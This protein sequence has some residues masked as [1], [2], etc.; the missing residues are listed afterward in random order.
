MISA[1]ML[2]AVYV[3][4]IP[5]ASKHLCPAKLQTK[6]NVCCVCQSICLFFPTDSGVPRAVDVQKC[7]QPNIV[8]GCVLVRAAHSRLYPLQKVHWVFGN[9][10]MFN[11]CVTLCIACVAACIST[12][13][14][15]V[16]TPDTAVVLDTLSSLLDRDRPVRTVPCD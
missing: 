16:M 15:E 7:L 11:L 13:R 2:R 10:G 14:L 9:D 8:L 3:Q 12:V 6:C 5:Q 4:R 1:V